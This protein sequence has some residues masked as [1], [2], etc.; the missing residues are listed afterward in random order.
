[1]IS[2]AVAPL[3]LFLLGSLACLRLKSIILPLVESL[4]LSQREAVLLLRDV[5]AHLRQLHIFEFFL[6]ISVLAVRG[7]G[8]PGALIR[9][10]LTSSLLWAVPLG[11]RGRGG[12]L[13]LLS[14]AQWLQLL[15]RLLD[16][17]IVVLLRAVLRRVAPCPLVL[18]YPL[19]SEI[20]VLG[21]H[22]LDRVRVDALLI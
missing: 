10:R 18:R 20:P 22:A 12:L 21:A 4:I 8:L 1:M 14:L 19:S 9:L 15:A 7:V 16:R 5:G 2:A 11:D 13:L 3:V 17:F 6:I